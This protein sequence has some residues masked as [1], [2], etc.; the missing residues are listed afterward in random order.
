M[1]EIINELDLMKKLGISTWDNLSTREI[2]GFILM[3]LYVEQFLYKEVAE[4]IPNLAG[5]IA[6]AMDMIIEEGKKNNKKD[7]RVY[8]LLENMV[9]PI[10]KISLKKNLQESDVAFISD[11]IKII[12]NILAEIK[13]EKYSEWKNYGIWTFVGIS[14]IAIL[15]VFITRLLTNKNE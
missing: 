11:R 5:R 4:K 6:E 1:A 14:V 12:A 9:R 7:I 15:I 3:S 13:K 10:K 8:E 2:T